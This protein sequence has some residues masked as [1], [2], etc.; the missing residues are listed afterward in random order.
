MKSHCLLAIVALTLTATVAKA[1]DADFERSFTV[2]GAP[3]V[4]VHTGSGYIHLY[5]G[6]P[7]QVRVHGHVHVRDS[8]A[9]ADR[10]L[11]DILAAPPVRQSGN[12]ITAEPPPHSTAGI[13]TDISIDYDVIAPPNST[14][15]AKTGSGSL[16]I[17]GIQGEVT[18]NTG[19][20]GIHVDNIGAKAQLGTGS[21]HIQATALH[22]T[23]SLHTGSWA[24]WF[25]SR[26]EK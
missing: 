14:V 24:R 15:E 26:S 22:G 11:K 21:G 1:A 13:F 25:Q 4:S 5:S 12:T 16:E 17:G 9:D 6:P 23:A 2:S 8:W 19:S 3:T 10:V 7:N 18:A 20:G